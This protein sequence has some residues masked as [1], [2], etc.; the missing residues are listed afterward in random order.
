MVTIV[1]VVATKVSAVMNEV[2]GSGVVTI[3]GVVATKVSAVMN[4]EAGSGMVTMNGREVGSCCP[5]PAAFAAGGST[6]GLSRCGRS[7]SL[8]GVRGAAR[9]AT[10][11]DMA[12]ARALA[13]DRWRCSRPGA[14][15]PMVT[16]CAGQLTLVISKRV[17]S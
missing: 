1:G 6:S 11:P 16:Y 14:V 17:V 9:G 7:I 10:A 5:W 13:R 8:A 3:V 4:E 15:L 12:A 2:A